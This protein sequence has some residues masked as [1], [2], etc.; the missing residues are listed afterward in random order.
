MGKIYE[1]IITRFDGGITND[2]REKDF[3]FA[4]LVRNFDAHSYSNKLVPFFASSD[5]DASSATN[6]MQNFV[7]AKYAANDYRIFGLGV[8]GTKAKVFVNDSLISTSWTG[9]TKGTASSQTAV[10]F[11][12]F[13]YYAK[14]GRIY[15]AADGTTIWSC[16]PADSV[17]FDES[18]NDD[19]YA[20]TLATTYDNP[21]SSAATNRPYIGGL[22]HSKDD[23]LY[24]F[25]DNII[26]KNNGTTWTDPALT[27]PTNRRITSICEYGNYLAIA[28]KTIGEVGNSVV[29]LWDRDSSLATL[30]ESVDW[31]EGNLQI[32]ENIEGA[33]VGISISATTATILLSKI[34][35]RYYTGGV[36]I[37]FRQ[38]ISEAIY[39]SNDLPRTKRKVDNHLY[40]SM[41]IKIGGTTHEGLWKVGK[42]IITKQLT[43]SM[44]RGANND[45]ALTTGEIHSFYVIGDIVFISYTDDSALA[46]ALVPFT[47]SYTAN[48]I[49]ESLILNGNDSSKTKKLLGVTTMSESLPTAGRVTLKYK[50]DNETTWTTIFTDSTTTAGSFIV[51]REYKIVSVGTTDFTTIGASA[52]TVGI[53]FVATGVGS[54]TGTAI[55]NLIS[56]S[57]I[58]I[59]GA[60]LPQYKEIQY[61]IISKGGAVITGLKFRYEIIEKDIYG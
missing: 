56:H 41:K 1:K 29:Y 10:D 47:G 57:A 11:E 40:F 20:I 16:D 34:T 25:H 53:V 28:T 48:S 12:L 15:G 60:T 43:L 51:G 50:K 58:N 33:L 45:S 36:P 6:K 54:G 14:T 35:F 39:A 46:M 55:D 4:R 17:A 9:L 32:L 19:Q 24:V 27:L 37:I 18:D 3:R 31:G 38:I 7:V 26:S 61:Q 13:I 59:S 49:Y 22:V 8:S 44:D 2:P 42:N 52:S 5:G 23:V 21:R 30:S